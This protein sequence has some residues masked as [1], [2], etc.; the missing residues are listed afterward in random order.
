MECS[1]GETSTNP[2]GLISFRFRLRPATR[3]SPSLI[4]SRRRPAQRRE[5]RRLPDRSCRPPYLGRIAPFHAR[6]AHCVPHG[7]A[8]YHK[9]IPAPVVTRDVDFQASAGE[10][11]VRVE[12][13]RQRVS[14]SR[15][16]PRPVCCTDGACADRF[17]QVR[18][19]IRKL[20]WN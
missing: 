18:S 4:S 2:V 10:M 7:K 17:P 5:P 3:R 1:G 6:Q 15:D 20:R 16:Q 11:R 14:I 8:A 12:V 9:V 13:I 19:P